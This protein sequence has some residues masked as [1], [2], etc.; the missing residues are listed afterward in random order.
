MPSLLLEILD[1]LGNFLR[2]V[3]FLVFGL[4]LA[5][6]MLDNFK[7]TEWQVQAAFV[8]GL[9]ALAIG[10]THYASPGS[11]GAFALGAGISLFMAYIPRTTDESSKKG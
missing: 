10:L 5:R 9:V 1:L 3:G 4:A 8:L 6:F 11:A 2:A 7:K